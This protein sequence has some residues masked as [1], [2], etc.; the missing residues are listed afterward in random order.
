MGV[1][2]GTIVPEIDCSKTFH[3]G[4]QW[5]AKVYT[6]RGVLVPFKWPAYAP[7]RASAVSHFNLSS[8]MEMSPC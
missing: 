7:S 5:F 8:R 2:H 3:R 6:V 4:L 1:A